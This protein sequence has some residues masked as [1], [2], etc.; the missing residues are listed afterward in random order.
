[1]EK[2]LT[3]CVDGNPNDVV[4]L[5]ADILQKP[6]DVDMEDNSIDIEEVKVTGESSRTLP[7]CKKMK[8]LSPHWLLLKEQ[9]KER[10]ISYVDLLRPDPLPPRMDPRR[11]PRVS[12]R[13]A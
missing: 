2:D 1:V 8:G 9:M 4:D 13:L 12:T 7:F 11:K 5:S 6:D 10:T 3:K